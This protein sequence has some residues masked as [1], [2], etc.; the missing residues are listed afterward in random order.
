MRRKLLAALLL[1]GLVTGALLPAGTAAAKKKKSGP[2]VVATDAKGD[3]GNNA[4][5]TIAPAGDEMGGDLIEASIG[6][7]DKATINF[8][9]AVNKLPT[10]G[11]TPETMRYIWGLTL[12]DGYLELDGKFTNYS[13]G[14]CDPTAG[15]CPPPRDPGEAPFAVRGNCT[16]TES[17]T[18][19]EEIG[20]VHASF[21]TDANTITVPVPLE[22][23]GAKPGSKLTV[24]TS[25]FA[26]SCGGPIIAI[27]S[28]FL[29]FCPNYPNDTMQMTGTFVV[30]RK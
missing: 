4:D 9:L 2:V 16:T 1:G 10:S 17:V 3:W 21:D 24:G 27:L 6:M 15:S 19:C 5:P 26:G 12:D 30:P 29:S 25:D 28:S 14:A 22:M 11:G 8:M 18:T 20:L 13:R 23:I 7:A